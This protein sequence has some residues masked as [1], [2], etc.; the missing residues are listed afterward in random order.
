M[1]GNNKDTDS[2]YA[3]CYEGN[4]IIIDPDDEDI[5]APYC[6]GKCETCDKNWGDED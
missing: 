5:G 6:D 3:F 4:C 2:I 1:P